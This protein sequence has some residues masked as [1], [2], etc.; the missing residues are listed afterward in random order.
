MIGI[1]NRKAARGPPPRYPDGTHGTISRVLLAAHYKNG[2]H[3]V[4]DVYGRPDSAVC[5]SACGQ[6][7]RSWDF[8]AG[9]G[10]FGG[11]APKNVMK[12]EGPAA[13]RLR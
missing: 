9:V 3:A 10:S 1:D 7:G 13:I 2:S 11:G 5:E 12:P 6:E 4:P 8:L